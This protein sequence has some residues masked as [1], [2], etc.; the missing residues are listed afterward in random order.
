MSQSLTQLPKTAD[1]EIQGWHTTWTLKIRNNKPDD[2]EGLFSE[3]M[4]IITESDPGNQILNKFEKH[5]I[6]FEMAIECC[7]QELEE[8][9]KVFEYFIIWE[10]SMGDSEELVASFS[11]SVA[12]RT[13]A[14]QFVEKIRSCNNWEELYNEFHRTSKFQQDI[15][16]RI[17]KELEQCRKV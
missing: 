5:G 10:Y 3:I 15:K 16:S 14:G 11:E 4:W 9:P 7:A 17:L 2:E 12:G 8:N 13:I 6:S 1:I